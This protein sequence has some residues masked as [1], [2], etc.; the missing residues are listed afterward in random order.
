MKLLTLTPYYA[1]A[2]GQVEATN[3]ILISL[4]KKHVCQKPRSL[5]ETLDQVLWA[6]RNSPKGATS[7]TPFKLVYGHEAILPIEINLN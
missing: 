5:H 1:Q 2:N 3:K 6:Y 4:I 7:V